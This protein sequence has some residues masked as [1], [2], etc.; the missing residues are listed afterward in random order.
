MNNKA[1]RNLS[2]YCVGTAESED[3]LRCIDKIFVESAVVDEIL[4]M[5][6]GSPKILVGHK[7]IGKTLIMTELRNRLTKKT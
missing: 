2:S 5:Y 4:E 1:L 7:G 6:P 3:G